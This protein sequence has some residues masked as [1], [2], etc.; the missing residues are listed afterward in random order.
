MY[1]F[2]DVYDH[3]LAGLI[4][5]AE[6]MSYDGVF[7]ENVISGY[8]TLHVTGRE[9]LESELQDETVNL[10]DGANY[11]GKRY[12]SRTITVTYQLIA[13][14]D[15]AFREAYNKMNL[16]LSNEQVQ[17]IFN[18]EPDK[19]FIGTKVSNTNPTPGRNTVTGT[20][21]IYCSDPFK[22]STT[23]KE[24]TAE[25]NE[26]GV[27]ELNI[28]NNGS[29]PVA[30]DYEVTMN[31]ETGF[32]G[33][34]S[35]NG[36]MQFGK[37]EEADGESYKQN[38]M[39]VH[40]SDFI[41]AP[42]DVNGTDYL[43]P[44]YGANGT[45][46]T[47]N[48]YEKTFL[49]FGSTGTRKGNASGGLRTVEIPLDSEKNKGAKNWYAYFHLLFYAGLMGQ[50]G[51]MSISFLTE[52]NK[53]IAAVNWNKTDTTGN[54][55]N[56][57]LICY[58][59]NAKSSDICQGRVLK[60]YSY[61]TS[62]LATQNPWYWDWGHCDLRKEGNKLTF[63]YWG[64]YPSFVIPEIENMVCTKI[65]IAVKQWGD[66]GGPRFLTYAG[67]N[68]FQFTKMNVE[69][70]RDVPNRYPKNTILS[71]NGSESKFY[72]NGMYKPSDEILGTSYFKAQ[73]G[74]NKVQVAV[75]EWTKTPPTVI[76]RIRE[77]WL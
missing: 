54:T 4:L 22:Y 31:S 30:I 57:D 44:H 41:K 72:V 33:L 77:A 70:W 24:F 59:P 7:L 3:N 34:I 76:A 52:D 9:L 20:I 51:E 18:D 29:V 27:L 55:G 13:K 32:L 75:S 63:Y 1:K 6:A 23:L 19:Y 17:I 25:T 73:S 47:T 58:N 61:T 35:E 2:K 8:R 62:H 49:K 45:L 11:L 15:Y 36:T 14:N 28:E 12:P 37:I 46:V 69:K 71:I 43:H 50:T 16:L 67:F 65:Q 42:D 26:D 38:E 53:L 66:R 60:T 40:L 64:S 21:E 68:V 56:Y 10:I 5:P 39:L 48:W 74:V